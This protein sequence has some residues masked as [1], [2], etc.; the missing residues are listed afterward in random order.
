MSRTGFLESKHFLFATFFLSLSFNSLQ[1]IQQYLNRRCMN[2]CITATCIKNLWQ[3]L[4][5][6]MFS[7]QFQRLCMPGLDI[8]SVLCL[9]VSLYT[10][11]TSHVQRTRRSP[12]IRAVPVCRHREIFYVTRHCHTMQG[13]VDRC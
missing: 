12:I 7:D 3:C 6:T 11:S 8:N 5:R 2:R 4:H 10:V 9:R 1:R 13:I